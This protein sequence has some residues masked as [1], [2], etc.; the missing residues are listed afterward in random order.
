MKA[1]TKKTT[2]IPYRESPPI[3]FDPRYVHLPVC[4]KI[5]DSCIPVGGHDDSAVIALTGLHLDVYDRRRRREHALREPHTAAGLFQRTHHLVSRIDFPEGKI[6]LVERHGVV[7]PEQLRVSSLI[8][9]RDKVA[10]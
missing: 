1:P 5:M 7:P 4:A 9:H 3:E 8:P 2:A 10:V 6:R